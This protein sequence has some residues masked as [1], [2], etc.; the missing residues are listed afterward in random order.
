MVFDVTQS[1]Y[2]CPHDLS[3]GG[4]GRDIEGA[5]AG[6]IANSTIQAALPS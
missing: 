3:E 6:S 5:A 2:L 1:L 4:R